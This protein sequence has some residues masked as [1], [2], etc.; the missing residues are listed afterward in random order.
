LT[1]DE[2]VGRLVVRGD[3]DHEDAEGDPDLR[4]GETDAW[5]CIHRLRH[6]LDQGADLVVHP[7][8][9]AGY[10]AEAGVG[11]DQDL[12]DGHEIGTI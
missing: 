5:R 2:Q 11:V 1:E 4:G 6:V 12:A 3:V 9:D 8:H 7:L 10:L